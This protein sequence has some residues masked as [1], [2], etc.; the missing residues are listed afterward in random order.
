LL[1]FWIKVSYKVR[2]ISE[3]VNEKNKKERSTI[4]KKIAG[5]EKILREERES[6]LQ[7]VSSDGMDDF[8][9]SRDFMPLVEED[10]KY[11]IRALKLPQKLTAYYLNKLCDI[12]GPY[13]EDQPGQNKKYY[14]NDFYLNV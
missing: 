1:S 7:M 2:E 11:R 3:N 8:G 13:S 12:Y 14:D 9:S 10:A 5:A 6:L 4:F